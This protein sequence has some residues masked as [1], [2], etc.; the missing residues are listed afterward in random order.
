MLLLKGIGGAPTIS[1]EKYVFDTTFPRVPLKVSRGVVASL[2]PIY[3]SKIKEQFYDN[4]ETN[5]SDLFLFLSI[6][7]DSSDYFVSQY[8]SYFLKYFTLTSYFL[9]YKVVS[10]FVWTDRVLDLR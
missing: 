8:S 3:Y 4:L 10:F 6:F 2:V 5:M 1:K 9:L 7:K